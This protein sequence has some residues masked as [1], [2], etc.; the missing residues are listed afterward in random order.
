MTTDAKLALCLEM[1]GFVPRVW[2]V[3]TPEILKKLGFTASDEVVSACQRS[4][5]GK[6]PG[7]VRYYFTRTPELIECRNAFYDQRRKNL[8][9]EA[10]DTKVSKRDIVRIAMSGLMMR[11]GFITEWRNA[12][13][14]FDRSG[15]STLNVSDSITVTAENEHEFRDL[16]HKIGDKIITAATRSVGSLKFYNIKTPKGDLKKIGL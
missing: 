2:N 14:F 7:E 8:A 6:R 4:A 5:Q 11:D 15:A 10:S 13:I 12:P 1:V 9:R 16:G 3:Y